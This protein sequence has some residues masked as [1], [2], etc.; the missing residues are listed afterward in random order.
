MVTAG[1]E[2]GGGGTRL[3]S[4]T[5][6]LKL[7]KGGTVM[8]IEKKKGVISN[9]SYLRTVWFATLIRN[10]GPGRAVYHAAEDDKADTG[11]SWFVITARIMSVAPFLN[12][13]HLV[14]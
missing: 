5:D 4:F 3:E 9:G 1:L 12:K 14:V 11:D 10:C 6:I 7:M 13:Q 8:D 2:G